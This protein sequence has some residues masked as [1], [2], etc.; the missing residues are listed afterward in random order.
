MRAAFGKDF[1]SLEDV[2][3]NVSL[4]FVNSN[5]FFEFAR[6]LSHKVV[7]IGGIVV[8][9]KTVPLS[10]VSFQQISVNTI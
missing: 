1:P 5:E 4:I 6:P 7:H 2:G 8:Q 10:E 9:P 3:K